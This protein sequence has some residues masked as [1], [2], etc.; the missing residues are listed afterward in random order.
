[1]AKER[2]KR[3]DRR[4]EIVKGLAQKCRTTWTPGAGKGNVLVDLKNRTVLASCGRFLLQFTVKTPLENEPMWVNLTLK[5]AVTGLTSQYH[6]HLIN[7]WVIER[8]IQDQVYPLVRKFLYPETTEEA[9]RTE[10]AFGFKDAE[11]RPRHRVVI[12]QE[13]HGNRYF[14][15]DDRGLAAVFLR[16]FQD[17]DKEGYWYNVDL[18]EPLSKPEPLPESVTDPDMQALYAKKL[19]AHKR[20]LRDIEEA[21]EDVDL[22]NRAKG[23]D[24]QAAMRFMEIHGDYQYEGYDIEWLTVA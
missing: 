12:F 19:K 16:V 15:V 13:K 2:K 11:G 9:R 14:F 1:M 18:P 20:R 4:D 23:G 5:D 17:R 6:E 3:K 22:Y 8:V 10:I 7:Y 24:A 21:R